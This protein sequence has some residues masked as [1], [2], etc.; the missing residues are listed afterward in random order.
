MA[1]P[2]VSDHAYLL[3]RRNAPGGTAVLGVYGS[4]DLALFEADGHAGDCDVIFRREGSHAYQVLEGG[5]FK[6]LV[7]ERATVQ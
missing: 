5:V 6:G 1:V 2:A 3:M 7:I 4:L